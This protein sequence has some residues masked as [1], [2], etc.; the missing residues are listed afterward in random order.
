MV[1]PVRPA[2]SLPPGPRGP[3]LGTLVGPGRDPL[4]LFTRFARTYGDV[5]TFRILGARAFLINHPDHIRDVLVTHQR[6]FTKSFALERAKRL[7]GNGL[8]T[9]EGATHLRHRR[10]LQP[11]FHRDRVA[12]YASVMVEHAD[13]LRG[14]WREGEQRD[15]SKDMMRLTL[16][17][18]AKALFDVDIES[19]ADAVGRALTDVIESFWLTLLPLPRLIERLPVPVVRRAVAARAKLDSLIYEMIAERRATG[20]RGDLLSLLLTA[21]ESETEGGLTDAEIRDEAMTLLLAGHET[22]AN[23]MAWTWHLLGTAPR[24]E[25]ALHE[26]IDRV[27]GGRLPTIDDLPAL[28]FVEQVVTESMRLYPP[29]WVIGRR[30][31][32]D[33]PLG[34]YVV[35]A[36]SLIFMS[37][38]VMHRDPRYYEE[39]ERFAPE[40]WT[41][42]FKA[43]LPKFAYFPFGGGA[44][45]C[46]GEPFAW[47]ELVLLVATL[48]QHWAFRPVAGQPAVPKPL[49]TLRPGNGVTMTLH[50][51]NSVRAAV[52]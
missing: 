30:A 47:M 36:R 15:L 29:A 4:A 16:S 49:I 33:Y 31:I 6:N 5:V 50:R 25:A 46:I 3:L 17:I 9:S 12:G 20:D 23:A 22:T 10:L 19:R 7:L 27:L 26:Q 43:S 18:V 38:W 8:L 24:V 45:Q 42:A 11:R 39:P 40:R 35:P 2:A 48:A 32:A 52:S 37:Q 21:Q 34:P 41:P 28:G 44:R 1:A 14:D 13:R 51:R